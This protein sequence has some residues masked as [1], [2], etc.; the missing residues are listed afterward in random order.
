MALAGVPAVDSPASHP[1]L[2]VD[3]ILYTIGLL[4]IYFLFQV[5]AG[6]KKK[7][8]KRAPQ[9]RA[10]RPGD[11]GQRVEPAPFEDT[12]VGT[13]QSLEDA[14]REIREALGAPQPEPEPAPRPAPQTTPGPDP[15]H[16]E[17]VERPDP[18]H[19]QAPPTPDWHTQPT[20]YRDPMASSPELHPFDADFAED[21]FEEQTVAQR[22][23]AA[24]MEDGL[25]SRS[26]TEAEQAPSSYAATLRRRLREPDSA[27]D[28]VVLAAIF[29]KPRSEED[30]W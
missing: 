5:F 6:S 3:D 4:V 12:G 9:Q 18:W 19:T 30:Y 20:P 23:A 21:A 27:R 8:P 14:L 17:P 15:W 16:T 10:P 1:A 22:S 7:P 28:A 11:E 29:G 2:P 25:K 13:T 26:Q 24:I